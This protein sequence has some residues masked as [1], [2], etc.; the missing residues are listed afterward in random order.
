M[1]TDNADLA[2]NVISKEILN[3]SRTVEPKLRV[4]DFMETLDLNKFFDSEI[5]GLLGVPKSQNLIII[6]KCRTF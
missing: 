6:R 2:Q 5:S 3:H 4:P 1:I